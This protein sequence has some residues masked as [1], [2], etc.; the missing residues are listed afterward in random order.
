MVQTKNAQERITMDKIII[1]PSK[2]V[3]GAN[4]LNSIGDYV[5]PLGTN[6]LAIADSFVTNLVGD[7]VS[8]SC[9]SSGVE[10]QMFE[11][12]GECSRPEIE[13]LMTVAEKMGAE[14]I[15]GIGGGKT[16]DT[17]KAVAFYSKIQSL[18]F[19]P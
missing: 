18:L 9:T 8:K 1:S 7:T 11:F 6:V 13:R 15:V 16:L 5:K 3:Q 2:Y 19:R 10:L 4:V 12:V 17:A 14:A